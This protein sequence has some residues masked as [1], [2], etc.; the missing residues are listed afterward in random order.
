MSRLVD[1][2]GQTL[3]GVTVVERTGAASYGSPEA[4]E[5]P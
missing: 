1:L 2:T 5:S 4:V 3:A